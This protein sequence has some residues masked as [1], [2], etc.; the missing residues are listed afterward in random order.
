MEGLVPKVVLIVG[1]NAEV[2]LLLAELLGLRG[3]SVCFASSLA[4]A[5]H[6]IATQTGIQYVVCSEDLSD[7][8]GLSFLIELRD[9]EQTREIRRV[10]LGRESEPHA[11]R[12]A[13]SAIG[14]AY[15]PESS[16]MIATIAALL[17]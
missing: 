4:N 11:L 10:L 14:A 12:A 17:Y 5:R 9:S 13:A 15:L 2:Q 6:T 7:G 3:H 1:K 16:D 8:S